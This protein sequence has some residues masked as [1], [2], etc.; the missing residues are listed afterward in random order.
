MNTNYDDMYNEVCEINNLICY[1]SQRLYA[2][3]SRIELQEQ[4]QN[5][6]L[7]ELQNSTEKAQGTLNN[8]LL[9]NSYY[10]IIESNELNIQAAEL[11]NNVLQSSLQEKKKIS[12]VVSGK[13]ESASKE[14]ISVKEELQKEVELK[15]ALLEKEVELK[16]ALL[17]KEAELKNALLEKKAMAENLNIHKYERKIVW[18]DICDSEESSEKASK[19]PE[20]NLKEVSKKAEEIVVEQIT[21]AVENSSDSLLP[22]P[23]HVKSRDGF[24]YI[25]NKKK[26]NKQSMEKK[27]LGKAKIS[28]LTVEE[29]CDIDVAS[30]A[31]EDTYTYYGVYIKKGMY[32]KR[33]GSHELYYKDPEEYKG[34]AGPYIYNGN[35]INTNGFLYTETSGVHHIAVQ[36]GKFQKWTSYLKN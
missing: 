20:D 36:K 16:N 25:L 17:E 10:Y 8:A 6:I 11:E 34:D 19:K 23:L 14:L 26:K 27:V 7:E 22:G 33:V 1:L 18:S 12:T 35:Y 31:E 28:S 5:I 29:L 2:F 9:Y 32:P 4:R 24:T 30:I 3:R 15:N 13:L 21:N